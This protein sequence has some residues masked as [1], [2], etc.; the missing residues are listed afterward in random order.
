MVLEYGYGINC[1]V[2]KEKS[3]CN[4]FKRVKALVPILIPLFVSA[5]RR[6]NDLASA[7]E[8]RCY[9]GGNGR[10]KM[11]PL[12]YHHRDVIGYLIIWFYLGVMIA[13]KILWNHFII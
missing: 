13:G 6:A 1:E 10:T 11:K 2:T 5:I 7:M 3:M 9:K 4:F 8:A 12:K